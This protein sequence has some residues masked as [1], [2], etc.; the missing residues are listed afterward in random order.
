MP[1][2][3][4][5]PMVV[6]GIAGLVL[7]LH[8][9]G[10]SH[11]ATLTGDADARAAWAREFPDDTATRVILS[12]DHHAALIET[13]RGTGIV[14]HM[15][16]DTTA[17]YLAGAHITRTARGLRIDLPDYTAPHINL[18]LDADEADKWPTLLKDTA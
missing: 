5:L 16:A 4:L 8:L 1:L 7:L 9:L 13:A 18:T 15:G 3:I 10:L 14:W 12:H 2:S 11:P 6:I 17:R